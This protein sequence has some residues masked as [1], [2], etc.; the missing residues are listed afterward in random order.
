MAHQLYNHDP[1]GGCGPQ[2]E[3]HWSMASDSRLNT[4]L[5]YA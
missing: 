1:L 2:I 4:F 3:K 5:L